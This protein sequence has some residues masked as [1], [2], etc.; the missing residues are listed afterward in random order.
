MQAVREAVSIPVLA[1]GNIRNLQDVH[2]C[3]AYTGVEGVMSAESLLEDPALFWPHRLTPEGT[4]SPCVCL[5]VS[6]CVCVCMAQH[7]LCC[8]TERV[9]QAEHA[10]CVDGKASLAEFVRWCMLWSMSCGHRHDP[11]LLS[12]GYNAHTCTHAVPT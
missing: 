12:C 5:C 1:N 6:L 4:E 11:D 3:I 8:V 2:D 7:W 9:F 10:E